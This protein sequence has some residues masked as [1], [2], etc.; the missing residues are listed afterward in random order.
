MAD[1]G[2]RVW[3]VW[4]TEPTVPS[5]LENKILIEYNNKEVKIDIY[6]TPLG[7]RFI[8]ALKDNLDQKRILRKKLLFL[9]LGRFKE[10]PPLSLQRA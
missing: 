2:W 6:D 9:R 1:V 3:N 4:N 10:R 8:E 5:T 7:K